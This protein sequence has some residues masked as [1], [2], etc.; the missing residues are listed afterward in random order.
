MD[1]ETQARMFE[2]FFSTKFTGRGLGMATTVG[3]VRAHNG[4]I[5]VDSAPGR[6]TTMT[7][8]LPVVETGSVPAADEQVRDDASSGALRVL[9]VDDEETVLRVAARLLTAAGHDVLMASGGRE[10]VDIVRRAPDSVDC[11]LLD[12]TMPGMDGLATLRALRDI[13]A[14]MPIVLTSGF[15]E[16]DAGAISATGDFLGFLQKPYLASDLRRAIAAAMRRSAGDA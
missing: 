3:V 14:D 15:S 2:P 7:V 12:M 8:L 16:A 5:L 11:V 1:A 9:A 6:G 13:R 4:V 10:A